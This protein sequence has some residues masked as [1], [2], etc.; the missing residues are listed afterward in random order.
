MGSNKNV[1]VSDVFT[2]YAQ[3]GNNRAN[4]TWAS[5]DESIATVTE[6]GEV[7]I[8]KSGD[9]TITA[10]MADE[11]Y[12]GLSAEL[13]L[14][15]AK[16][17]ITLSASATEL[18][19][20]YNGEAQNV[21]FTAGTLDLSD[22]TIN[23]TYVMTTDA[24][25]TEPKNV[26]TYA[27]SYVIDDERYEGDGNFT[28]V[29]NKATVTV[30]ADAISKEYGEEPEYKLIVSDNVAGIDADVIKTFAEFASDGAAKTANVGE[31]DIT[32]TLTTESDE[33]C[34]YVV[35]TEA[36]G[37]LTV[38]PAT[39]TVNVEDMSREYGAEN[40][41]ELKYT[42]TGFKNDET[43]EIL[44]G[45]LAP[46]YAETIGTDVATY[47]D[48]ITAAGT[49]ENGNYTVQI[50]Y[51]DGEAAD[52]TITKIPVTASKGTARSSY[53]T[54][55]FDKAVEGVTFTVTDGT[56]PVEITSVT[57]SSDNKTYT[58]KGSFS[59]SVTYTVTPALTSETHE[60]TS[61][62]LSIKPTS[63]GGGGGGGGSSA[64]T[65]YTVKFE[66]DG[67]SEIDS[68]KVTKNKTVDE[69]TAPT[70]DG[71]TFGGWYTDKELK[72]AYDFDTKVTKGF[73]LY[74][75]WTEI[76]KEPEDTDTHNCPSETFA[77]LDTAAWYHLDTD[78][79]IENGIFKGVTE[80]TFAPNDKL[81]RAMLVTVLYRVEGEP[82]TNRSIPFA[83]VDMGAYYANAVSWAKQNGIVNGVSETEFAPNDNITREQIAAI[84]HRYAQYKG[85]DVSVGENTNILSYDDFDNISE[86]AIASMQYAVG[87]GLMK[88]KTASTLNPKD[89]ATRAEIAAILHRFIEA[90]K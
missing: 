58:L 20:T 36:N 44:T 3:Y 17:R 71:Y 19:K 2:L 62:P 74:A 15:A 59:T 45:S 66:T 63:S 65:I 84:M 9:V 85:Y 29:I 57:A 34:N 83:D 56:N 1:T 67:G 11:N 64:P 31:Y 25:Q 14:T 22:I 46:V 87:S 61:E 30:S 39:L 5:S 54:I 81:T 53:L 37:K 55:K 68:V 79:A 48:V 43:A 52:L 6:N 18:I 24:S 78:Y 32:V 33:N 4:V 23:T 28:L 86:Y 50:A 60:I 42:I 70:K 10:T 16:K 72:T 73:T 40:P 27:V 47:E 89:N 38:T 82:A 21:T 90:N 80:T 49:L 26:G 41:T 75:K 69:P 51:A 76:E 7:T 8:L 13:D 12:G 35:N 77:D 88:G